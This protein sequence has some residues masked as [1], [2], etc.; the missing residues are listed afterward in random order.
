M[1]INRLQAVN[2]LIDWRS[3]RLYLPNDAGTSI[4]S[5]DWVDQAHKTGT[6]KVLQH[7]EELAAL[8]DT[9]VQHSVTVLSFPKFGNILYLMPGGT[10]FLQRGE[11]TF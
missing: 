9:K 8:R 3:S 1:G 5:G 7:A 10:A 4:L 6:V 11:R 2:P